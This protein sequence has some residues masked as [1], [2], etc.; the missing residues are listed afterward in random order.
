MLM[1]FLLHRSQRSRVR[2]GASSSRS[3]PISMSFSVLRDVTWSNLRI[4]RLIG[5]EYR[6]SRAH[7]RLRIAT[8][9]ATV[10]LKVKILFDE[11]QV[12]LLVWILILPTVRRESSPRVVSVAVA[13]IELQLRT[14]ALPLLFASLFEVHAQAVW[15]LL[16]P[17]A[18]TSTFGRRR[19]T[20]SLRDRVR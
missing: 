17:S 13:T 9:D 11:V 14:Y 4:S 3:L 2:G 16:R 19:I 10:V 18:A 7:L 1:L 8:I 6:T 20:S 5:E 12:R 15:V